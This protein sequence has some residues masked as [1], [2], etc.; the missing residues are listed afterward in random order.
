MERHP[1]QLNQHQSRSQ[2]QHTSCRRWM[3]RSAWCLPRHM[4]SDDTMLLGW[5]HTTKMQKRY[6][7]ICRNVRLPLLP[8]SCVDTSCSQTSPRDIDSSRC[9]LNRL[10]VCSTTRAG[11]ALH[12]KKLQTRSL[13]GVDAIR[14]WMDFVVLGETP[15]PSRR[16]VIEVCLRT[17]AT[18]CKIVEHHFSIVIAL[19]T[20]PTRLALARHNAEIYG[21]ADR[22]EF[23]Q[24]D[25]LSFIR[26]Q[27]LQ[28]NPRKIDVIF[29]SPP[30][31]G[32][33]YISGQTGPNATPST[34]TP[35]PLDEEDKHPEYHLSSI[36]PIH[37]A[38]LFKLSRQVT[39]NIAYFLPRNTNLAEIGALAGEE[40]VEVEE[41]WTG[42]KLKALTCYYG[43][44]AA[45]QEHLF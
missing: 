28:T 14:Y 8:K 18:L 7:N 43:G 32:I 4:G 35:Q 1:T 13:N 12:L 20:S 23:I 11:S 34:E 17:T 36:Q 19:D 44:L 42:T 24:A 33:A 29:L 26:M 10:D 6:Q 22:I 37:G 2:N 40:M 45:G 30:W 5:F 41:E 39:P 27:S 38:E 21:V 3:R 16:L 9:I 31:G 15:L 25:Y